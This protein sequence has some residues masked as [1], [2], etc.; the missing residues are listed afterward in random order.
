MFSCDTPFCAAITSSFTCK[1]MFR[2][3]SATLFKSPRTVSQW[4]ATTCKDTAS[5]RI[6][7]LDEHHTTMLVTERV[8]PK[9]KTLMCDRL[10]S[11]F[12]PHDPGKDPMFNIDILMGHKTLCIRLASCECI[13][14]LHLALMTLAMTPCSIPTS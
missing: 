7:V 3:T 2:P 9:R 4:G 5:L 10:V 1:P 14:P 6:T 13:E 11:P 12:C 8:A